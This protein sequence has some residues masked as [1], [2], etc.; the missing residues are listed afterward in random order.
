MS[1]TITEKILAK[2]S[3]KDEV[4]PGETVEARIDVL[5]MHDITSSAAIKLL[6]QEFNNK[7]SDDL[8]IVVVPDHYVPSKD[9]N[10][11][12]LYQELKNFVDEQKASGTGIISYMIEGGDYGVCHVMLPEKGH[13][14]P[15]QVLVGGD[16]HTC[17][18]GALGAFST[19]IGTTEVGNVLATGKLWFRIPES[20]K[21]QVDGE[22]PSNAMAKDLF[23]RVV[24]D[25]GVDGALYQAMEWCG[26]TIQHMSMDERMTLTN[27]AIEAGAKSGIIAPDKKTIEYIKER[28]TGEFEV[29]ESDSDAE[30][31][32]VKEVD[33]SSLEPL[34][35][36]PHLPSN[37]VPASELKDVKVDQAYIGSCTGGK[38]EDFVAAAEVLKGE[39]IASHVRLL[40]VPSTADIQKRMVMEGLYDIFMA[41]G[42][43]FSAPTCGACLG[44]YMGILAPGEAAISSTNRNFRG[45]MGSPESFVYLASPKT[46]A[47]TAVAGYIRGVEE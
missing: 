37:V 47:A 29:F 5:M 28:T 2:A 12:V 14:L 21:L 16:S 23:L 3:G 40:I 7:V 45:R 30:Y 20:H 17:T 33:A 11:A 18:Y 41:A 19:G 44:G 1:Q 8:K 24:G 43:V 32:S 10:S 35:A 13:V 9:I 25:I 22:M 26:E 34:V 6:K 38:W 46:V 39:R 4:A 31:S 42:A 36:K 15:G 27:M